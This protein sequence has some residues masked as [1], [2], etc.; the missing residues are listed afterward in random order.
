LGGEA[1]V[2]QICFFFPNMG[3]KSLFKIELKSFEILV[4]EEG[5]FST[6]EFTK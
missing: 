4:E 2:S 3:G 6:R 1:V 5:L